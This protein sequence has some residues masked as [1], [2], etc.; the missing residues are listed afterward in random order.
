[1]LRL[2]D[3]NWLLCAAGD[4]EDLTKITDRI[5]Q[6]YA[7]TSRNRPEGRLPDI[8]FR[9]IG[10]WALSSRPEGLTDALRGAA[11]LSP[12]ARGIH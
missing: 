12:D 3:G 11:G 2:R 5:A 6:A 7:E 9:P 10:A 4:T 1:L 8:K